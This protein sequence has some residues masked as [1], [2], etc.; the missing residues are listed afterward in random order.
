MKH[1][2][3]FPSLTST[4]VALPHHLHALRRRR[5]PHQQV[6]LR[7]WAAVQAGSRE[8]T[9][10]PQQHDLAATIAN[11]FGLGSSCLTRRWQSNPLPNLHM[12][13]PSMLQFTRVQCQVHFLRTCR[14]WLSCAVL[15]NLC[16]SS[17]GVSDGEAWVA[18]N[19]CSERA[20]IAAVNRQWL[21]CLRDDMDSHSAQGQALDSVGDAA[22]W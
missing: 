19:V 22:V 12:S 20:G 10:A 16:S 1:H 2:C 8:Q 4:H 6:L 13:I 15:K 17:C 9:E 5:Q 21:C 11:W 7:G 14:Y 3:K 18:G